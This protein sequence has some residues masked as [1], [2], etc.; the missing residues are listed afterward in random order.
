MRKR[1]SNLVT[2]TWNEEKK[3]PNGPSFQPEKKRK[4]FS[5]GMIYFRF[6]MNERITKQQPEKKSFK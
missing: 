1:S 6:I 3:T 2:T 4:T 5:T